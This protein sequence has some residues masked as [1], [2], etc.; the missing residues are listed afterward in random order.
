MQEKTCMLLK[1]LEGFRAKVYT[2][3]GGYRTIGYGHRLTKG[4]NFSCVTPKQAEQLMLNDLL[5]A[6]RAVRRLISRPLYAYQEEALCLFTFNVGSG[7]LQRSIL[8]A[9]VNRGDHQEVPKEL[10]KWV[11][12]HGI[13]NKGLVVRRRLEGKL[14]CGEL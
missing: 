5:Q 3:S 1:K 8:R 13:I 12:I 11:Y 14:Y 10:L 9:K 2:C 6:R 7:A 4:E